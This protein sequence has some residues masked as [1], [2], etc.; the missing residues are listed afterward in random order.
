MLFFTALDLPAS[1]PASK[2]VRQLADFQRVSVPAGGH[3]DLVFEVTADSLTLYDE[4][5]NRVSYAGRYRLTFTNGVDDGVS[6]VATVGGSSH[7]VAPFP[8]VL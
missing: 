6:V 4:A 3:A 1:S 7:V 2:I 8:N 5:G